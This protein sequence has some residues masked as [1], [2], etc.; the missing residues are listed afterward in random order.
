MEQGHLTQLIQDAQVRWLKPPEV[1]FILQHHED[2]GFTHK[3]PH[4]PPSGSLFI[5]NRRVNRY[6]RNDG[7]SWLRKR[8]GRTLA[9]GHERLKVDNREVL[10]CY[11]TPGDENPCLRRR[12]YW[13]L[14]PAYEHIVLVHY[15]EYSE[16]TSTPSKVLNS[17]PSYSTPLHNNRS[18][19]NLSTQGLPSPSELTGLGQ[20]SCSPGS[21]DEV[22]SQLVTTK[23]DGTGNYSAE[24]INISDWVENYARL[25]GLELSP[26]EANGGAA[27]CTDVGVKE[28]SEGLFDVFFDEFNECSHTEVGS[29]NTIEMLKKSEWWMEELQFEETLKESSNSLMAQK[30]LFTIREISPEWAFSNEMTK[31]IITGDFSCNLP[32]SQLWA[33]FGEMQ[34]PAEIIQEGVLRCWS[35]RMGAGKVNFHVTN[36]A[37]ELCSEVREFE[38]R[39]NPT[40]N[41]T[42]DLE[43]LDLLA[44]LVKVLLDE[45]SEYIGNVNLQS[46][47][48]KLLKDK[49][50]NLVLKESVK[51]GEGRRVLPK[52]YYG[53]IHLISGLGFNWGLRLLLDSGVSVNYRDKNGWTALHWAARFGREE[54]VTS[55]ILAGAS[56][57][58]LSDPK[59]HSEG[60]TAAAIA[61]LFGH[62]GIAAYLSETRLINHPL[63]SEVSKPTICNREVHTAGGTE[64]QLSLKDSLEGARN[65]IQAATRIQ[66]A[67]RNF[68]FRRKNE[69]EKRYSREN[70]SYRI[71]IEEMCEIGSI[72]KF[73]KQ[74]HGS[75]PNP[76]SEKAVVSIQKN[77]RCWKKRKEFLHLRRNVVK[78]QAHYRGHQARN[79]KNL[80][81]T[82]SVLEKVVLR[83]LKRGVGLRGYQPNPERIDEEEESDI[84]KA[85]RKQRVK[86]GIDEAVS[87]VL[88]VVDSPDAR[89]QYRRML[90][91]YHQAKSEMEKQ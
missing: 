87:T 12:I 57:D 54:M 3:P 42:S 62:K 55:L 30:S 61:E 75:R 2:I 15:R 36:Q 73:H 78:I 58:A 44:K 77:F 18:Y 39:E 35:P 51:N 24:N 81:W 19:T 74:G 10:T 50:E 89:Q 13:M 37:G 43:E 83:W 48:E 9:E 60:R 46:L 65:A 63:A 5:F 25:E 66:Q 14:D 21:T 82:V 29:E 1:L 31:V 40:L 22:S 68:S 59:S 45:T 33:Q 71:S 28:T 34:V 26:S 56:A 79:Y 7:H 76:I 64:D 86:K 47:M 6:F 88:T 8:N 17:I 11:Y 67:F 23:G 52:K 80:L 70:S 85:F 90:V 53:I 32:K 16:G 91:R 69:I 72:V 4:K 49:L 27:G 38:F 84:I 41:S 20:N